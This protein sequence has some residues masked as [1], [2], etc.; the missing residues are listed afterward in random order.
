MSLLPE[1]D[2]KR[3]RTHWNKTTKGKMFVG[4]VS[5]HRGAKNYVYLCVNI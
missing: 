1:L 2:F 4:F 3:M 5:V